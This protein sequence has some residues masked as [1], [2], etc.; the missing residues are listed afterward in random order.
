MPGRWCDLP[1]IG[2]ADLTDYRSLALAGV[3]QSAELVR[4]RANGLTVPGADQDA[5]LAAITTHHADSMAE[6]FPVKRAFRAGVRSARAALGG[7]NDRSDVLRYVLQLL[8]LARRLR[9]SPGVL[10][11]LAHGLDALGEAPVDAALAALY[12][13]TI[14]TLGRRIHVTGNPAALQQH[15]TADTIRALLLGGVRFAWLWL[16]LG[17]RRWQLL[18]N[19]RV[20]LERLEALDNTL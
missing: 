19:R 5:V 2:T 15:G 9:R 7:E 17:G 3:F 6:V 13:D 10:E 4:S 1:V 8:D 12:Q 18:L 20:V 11:R 16:Q 14:S